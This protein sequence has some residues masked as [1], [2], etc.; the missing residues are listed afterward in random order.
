LIEAVTKKNIDVNKPPIVSQ[1][2]KID[3]MVLSKIDPLDTAFPIDNAGGLR[4]D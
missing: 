1:R 4:G 3:V 2:H